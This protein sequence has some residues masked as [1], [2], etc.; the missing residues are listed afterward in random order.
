M[1]SDSIVN[2]KN[3][4]YKIKDKN[5][6]DAICFNAHKNRF[7]GIIGTN[8]SGKTTM[9]KHLYNA[10]TPIKKTVFINGKALEEYRQNEIA[11][12][13]SVMKQENNSDFDYKVIDIVLMGR[14]PYKKAFEDYSKDDFNVAVSNL[15]KLGMKEFCNR[16]YN[17][18]SG[19]EKQRVLIARALNQDT[20]LM[21]LD[22]PTNHLDIYYQVFLMQVLK[23]VSKTVI[24]VF[25]DLN[26]AAKYCDEIYV[27]KNGGIIMNGT[28][29]EVITSSMIKEVF[30]L[31]SKIIKDGKE[32]YVVY[33][34]ILS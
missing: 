25:H 34:N 14:L 30:N 18:L 16:N 7:I 11:Q 23:S 6:L 24:S 5:I 13:L 17:S 9:L 21:I 3:L 1:M 20:E 31:S 10:I 19:G 29:K 4:S 22:E 12:T 27:L 8:G 28:P 26:L 15:T 32:L 33:N 2:I